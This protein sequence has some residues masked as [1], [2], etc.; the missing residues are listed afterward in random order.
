MRL[1][2]VID[3]RIISTSAPTCQ[4]CWLTK[5]CGTMPKFFM[6]KNTEPARNA[7]QAIA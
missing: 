5:V 4:L 7:P 1:L 6:R 2:S 3:S